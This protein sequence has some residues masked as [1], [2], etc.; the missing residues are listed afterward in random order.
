MADSLPNT[1][2]TAA[3]SLGAT[4]GTSTAGL[5]PW[6]AGYITDYLGKAKALAE[7]PQNI[8]QGPLTAGPSDLQTKA[9]QG[10]GNLTMPATTYTPVGGSFID[11]GIPAQFRP[12]FNSPEYKA[13][14]DNF[15]GP[16]LQGPSS[17]VRPDFN[18][19]EYKATTDD[20]GGLTSGDYDLNYPTRQPAPMGGTPSGLPYQQP[21][22]V[23]EQYMNPYMQQVLQ[24]QL[25]AMQRQAD[26]Q[27]NVLGAQAAK[28]GAFGGARSGLMEN[29][30]NAELMRQQ[31]EAT[32]KAYGS[33]YDKAMQQYNTEQARKIQEAQFGADYG[34]KNLAA[35]QNVLNQMAGFGGQQ[36]DIEQQGIAADYNEFLRQQQYPYQQLQFMREMISGL[37]TSSITNQ[38]AQLSGIAQLITAMGGADKLL[39]ATGQSDLSSILGG[40]FN[41]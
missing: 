26:I 27:R 36:R 16:M 23:A 20:F 24:P 11:R 39:K 3:S 19:P 31:Q 41:Q 37:P 40:L 1:T 34:L 2:G 12:D 33:A 15:G 28:S 32:G 18:S 29:Q 25:Q 35:Q 5:A 7:M 21:Q 17:L 38:P 14:T 30:L 10:I 9:F 8:Y 6:A 13:T 4:G 22:S